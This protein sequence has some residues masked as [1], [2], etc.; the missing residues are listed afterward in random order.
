[1]PEKGARPKSCSIEKKKMTLE[2]Q[3]YPIGK[4][5]YQEDYSDA[6]LKAMLLDIETFPA[7]LENLV[8]HLDEDQ[9]QT[10]YRDGG[11]TI[12]QVIHHCAD[13][14]MNC[15]LRVKMAL[16]DENP[17]IRPY[18]EAIWA[19]MADYQLPFNMSVTLLF[20]IHAK[21][22]ALF[23]SLTKEQLDRTYYHPQYEK[24][25]RVKDV[26]CLYAWHG[27]HHLAHIEMGIARSR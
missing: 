4:C 12:Q 18:P 5:Q 14:H 2:S 9:L 11:W 10:R 7:R 27:K 23:R 22:T 8:Q 19:E 16:S 17:T 26:I 1:M 3:Q 21:L 24:T 15:V 20:C 25:F 13:S 6:D